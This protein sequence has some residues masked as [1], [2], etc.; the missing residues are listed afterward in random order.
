MDE[1]IEIYWDDLKE[2]KQQELLS[3]YGDNGN[4]DVFPLAVLPAP[5]VEQKGSDDIS[6]MCMDELTM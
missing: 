5:E 3:I 1:P 4:W 2:E 6:Q